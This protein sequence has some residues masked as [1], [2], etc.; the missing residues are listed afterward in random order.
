ML[1]CAAALLCALSPPPQGDEMLVLRDGRVL[2]RLDVVH[3]E[4]GYTVRYPSG[5]VFV[6][7][8]LVEHALVR[9]APPFVPTS[10]EER[11]KVEQGLV[12]HDGKWLTPDKRDKQIEKQIAEQ[13]VILEEIRARGEWRNRYIHETKHFRFEYTVPEHVFAP[14]REKMEAYFDAFAKDWKI[15]PPRGLG[16]LPICFYTDYP[17]FLQ[18]SGVP[19]GVLGYF[20]FVDPMELNFFYDRTDQ[21]LIEEVMYHET[22]HYLQKLLAIDFKMPHFPGESLAE[23]YGASH[24]DHETREFTSGHVL[25]G[26]L[27]EVKQDLLEGTVWRLAD[28]V[29]TDGAY[30]HYTWGWTLVHYLMHDDRYAKLFQKFVRELCDGK[31]TKYEVQQIGPNTLRFVE[32]REVLR[33]FRECLDL[34]DD[35]AFAAL[36]QDWH[37]YIEE[38]LETTSPIGKADAAG[39]SERN[40]LVIKARRLYKEAIEE[41]DPRAI[42]RHRY[43]SALLDNGERDEA[44]RYWREAIE[45]DPLEALYR[46]R[47]G[48]LLVDRGGVEAKAEGYALLRLARDM[49]PDGEFQDGWRETVEIDWDDVLEDATD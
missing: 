22:N 29:G 35:E 1:A 9:E 17:Q 36:E 3:A 18:V 20:R 34:E 39:N 42:T 8:E 44:A 13:R 23:F 33:V 37:R 40:G 19:F 32:G 24:Y 21:A 46:Y 27:N 30:E 5:E 2:D 43:A 14:L 28:L 6:P 31:G 45:R 49:N 26:R 11:A 16:A 15:K 12:P 7:A 4:K 48:D 10:D 38:E 25:E 47:L 41:G